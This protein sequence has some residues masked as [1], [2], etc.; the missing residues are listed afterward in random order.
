V[1]GQAG[2]LDS[3]FGMSATFADFDHNG[4]MDLY[5]SNMFSAAG[6]RVT[7]QPEF[8]AQL[9][10]AQKARFQYLARGNSLFQNRGDGQFEDASVSH[11]VTL[12]RWSWGSLFADV[13]ND[14]WDDLL[15][16]NG[17]LTGE[18]VDDL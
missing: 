11:G 4:W 17:Y 15:V 7:F 9:S 8:K 16:A 12:G 18:S 2:L 13:N 14:S 6:N 1:A 10:E 3:A 5:V